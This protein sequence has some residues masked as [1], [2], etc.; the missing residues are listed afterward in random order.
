MLRCTRILTR[1]HGLLAFLVALLMLGS[2][3]PGFAQSGA[4]SLAT[5]SDH[6]KS[7][8]S[9]VFYHDGK[10]WAVAYD[11]T[12][13]SWYIYRFDNPAWVAS[14]A[15]QLSADNSLDVLMDSAT[16]K[17]YILSSHTAKSRFRRFTYRAGVWNLDAGF[18]KVFEAYINPNGNNP[19]SLAKAKNG[20]LWSF[21][22]NGNRKLQAKVSSNDGNTWAVNQTIKTIPQ[23]NATT[24]AVAFSDG[25]NNYI[26]VGYAEPGNVSSTFGFLYHKDGDPL[27]TWTDQTAAL[28]YFGTERAQNEISMTVDQH[29]NVYMFTRTFGGVTGNPRNTLYMRSAAGTWTA[30]NVNPIGGKGWVS[31]A[32]AID[33]E[34]HRLVVMGINQNSNRAE[35][36][37]GVLGAGSDL[38]TAPFTIFL[39]NGSDH[40]QNLSAPVQAVNAAMGLMTTAGDTTKRDTWYSRLT[41]PATVAVTIPS[42]KLSNN[43]VNANSADTLVIQTS[44]VGALVANL[45]TVTVRFPNNTF[46]PA[47]ITPGDITVNGTPVTVASINAPAREITFTTPVSVAN[48]GSFT[49]VFG[50]AIGMLNPSIFGA[51]TLQAWTSQQTTPGTSA[52]YNLIA[53]ATTVSAVKATPFPTDV[54]SAAQ[55]TVGFRVGAN[56]R[57]FSESSTITITLANDTKVTAGAL[58]GVTINGISA[59]ATGDNLNRRVNVEVPAAV[60]VNNGDSVTVFVPATALMNPSWV[61]TFNLEVNTSVEITKVASNGF[62][63]QK[64][65]RIANTTKSVERSNQSKMFYH[66]G[67]WWLAAQNKSNNSWYLWKRSDTTWTQTTLI[68]NQGKSRPDCILDAANNRAYILLPGNSTTFITRLSYASG[69]WTVDGGY[70]KSVGAVQEKTMNLARDVDGNLWVFWIADSTLLAR[71]STNEGSTWSTNIVVKDSLNT[72]IGLQ[73]AAPYSIGGDDFLGV[74]YAENNNSSNA[75]FGFLYHKDGDAA[76][77]WTDESSSVPQ[78]GGTHSDD[79]LSMLTYNGEVFMAVKTSGGGGNTT[80]QVGLLHRNTSG[81]WN[82]YSVIDDDG[83]TRPALAIDETNG[84][85]YVFGTHEGDVQFLEGKKVALGNYSALES[86]PL[87]TFVQ[88]LTNDFFD[89]STP[90]HTVTGVSNLLLATSNS[91]RNETW[92]QVIDLP[93]GVVIASKSQPEPEKSAPAVHVAVESNDLEIGAYP[94]PFNPSTHIQFTLKTAA[95]VKLQIF[96]INGQ[97]VRTLIDNDMA[98]GTHRRLWRGTNQEGR[99]VSSGTYFYRL[100]VGGMAKTGRLYMIK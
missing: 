87:D 45:S 97:L 90:G 69:A 4:I 100:Q 24:D 21:R 61:D 6:K 47:V 57:L 83:W 42:V 92:V 15:V 78:F 76:T 48:G 7:N 80:T 53:T 66:A 74:G 59:L 89:I 73:D 71:N 46:V 13:G 70:P 20:D 12:Q 98:A 34:N 86:A 67:F 94:N 41:I 29:N 3:S 99:A 77:A 8:Q 84:M 16:N 39:Q 31:P 14:K 38:Q 60:T 36:K 91:T 11:S 17:L 65:R 81:N 88:Y 75:V 28:T 5:S 85:V 49:V 23:L 9:K 30:F 79:H 50:A 93:D 52:I 22:V 1:G 63:F 25:V 68:H 64:G 18:P 10:W 96:N 35:Y 44:A 32:L 82:A 37:T 51:Q 54:D 27:A 95:P 58:A 19:L 62:Y 56:G 72:E 33:Q 40:F 55:Y 26:G 2:F 43:L